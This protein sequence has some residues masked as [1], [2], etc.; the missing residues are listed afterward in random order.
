MVLPRSIYCFGYCIFQT[1][2]DNGNRVRIQRVTWRTEYY[3]NNGIAENHL[4]QYPLN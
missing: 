4:R 3:T 1:R 2:M